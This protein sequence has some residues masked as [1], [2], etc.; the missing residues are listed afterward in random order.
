MMTLRQESKRKGKTG[1][2]LA[3]LIA[4]ASAVT[5]AFGGADQNQVST[6][7]KVG[8]SFKL[9]GSGG[10]LLDGMGDLNSFRLSRTAYAELLNQRPGY[11][12]AL[13]WNRPWFVP[14]LSADIII[15]I[16]RRFGIGIG[17]AFIQGKSKG[18]NSVRYSG[19]GYNWW[20][21]DSYEETVKS[22]G[23]YG[24]NVTAVPVKLDLY[25]FQ[26]LTSSGAISLFARAGAGYY[27]GNL[28]KSFDR[29][30]ESRVDYSGPLYVEE[31]SGSLVET[32]KD[33]ALGFHGGLG[34]EFMISRSVSFCSE[35]F[36]R[37]VDFDDWRGDLH[38]SYQSS[39]KAGDSSGWWREE[40]STETSNWKG[41]MWTYQVPD[42]YED[43]T[44][45]EM[46]VF[47]EKPQSDYLKQVRKTVINLDA[48]G[49]SFS[50]KF[51]F[52][53]F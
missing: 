9:S 26:P 45:T 12:S 13:D 43:L 32:A 34:V 4:V 24:F 1:I 28:K 49:I 40:S 27:F 30:R 37:F 16:G 29:Q 52:D 10:Y 22:I 21:G 8:I 6:R 19:Q 36:G 11:S 42:D 23:T 2:V 47:P 39:F 17:T 3:G 33:E 50:V 53:L 51:R 41:S 44:Y 46:Y 5:T 31:S 48:C 7:K 38:Y 35:V 14:D 25:F 15:N 18:V 20:S